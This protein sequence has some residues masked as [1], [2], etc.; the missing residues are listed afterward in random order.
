MLFPVFHEGREAL[1]SRTEGAEFHQLTRVITAGPPYPRVFHECHRSITLQALSFLN[2]TGGKLQ[3][4]MKLQC[5]CQFRTT[6]A[7]DSI[8]LH[9]FK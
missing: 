3:S 2:L 1:T 8:L 6:E 7:V 4:G 5:L 9:P